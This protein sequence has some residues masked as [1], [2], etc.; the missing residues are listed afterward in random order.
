MMVY[1]TNLQRT[2]PPA[3]PLP[4]SDDRAVLD[5]RRLLRRLDQILVP[6]LRDLVPIDRLWRGH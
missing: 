3:D 2:C 5:L 4:T 1:S 6:S